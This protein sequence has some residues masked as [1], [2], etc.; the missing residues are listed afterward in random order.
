MGGVAQLISD[1]YYAMSM[2]ECEFVETPPRS[3][4]VPREKTYDELFKTV[5]AG[6]Y[7]VGK[8]SL[9]MRFADDNFPT[10]YITTIG[11]DFK[12]KRIRFASK[13]LLLQIWDE[14]QGKER[15]RSITKTYYRGA[16]GVFFVFSVCDVE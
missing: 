11:I 14:P 7:G 9:L 13:A 1:Q 4:G 15:F 5:Q 10:N 2:F 12:I 16:H 8:S 3:A 6:Q